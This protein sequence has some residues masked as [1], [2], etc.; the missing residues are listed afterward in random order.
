M[1]DLTKM[2]PRQNAQFYYMMDVMRRFEWDMHNRIEQ[3]GRIPSEWHDI[4]KERPDRVK[5]QVNIGLDE[6]V[7][8]FFKSLGMGYGGRINL[9]LKS[10]M[11]AR[12][13]GVLEGAETL[14]HFKTWERSFDE[15]KPEFGLFAAEVG[16]EWEDAPG[17]VSREAAREKRGAVIRRAQAKRDAG[18]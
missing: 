3:S 5:R 1:P 16:V 2:T 12:L 17:D 9:I 14:N 7:L 4:A 13:A 6:D 10:F 18:R 8:K 11:H 15:P